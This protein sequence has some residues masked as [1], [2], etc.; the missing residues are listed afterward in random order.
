MGLWKGIQ[1]LLTPLRV[2]ILIV[3]AIGA[4][5]DIGVP[6]LLSDHPD[7][8][9]RVRDIR[10]EARELQCSTRLGDQSQWEKLQASLPEQLR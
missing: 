8:E 4:G 3:L 2:L 5:G 9:A 7:S 1:L 6:E 10:N